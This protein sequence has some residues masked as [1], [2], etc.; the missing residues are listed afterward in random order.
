MGASLGRGLVAVLSASW[1]VGLAFTCVL[2]MWL[3]LVLAGFRGPFSLLVNALSIP[4][5]STWSVDVVPSTLAGAGSG[6]GALAAVI[7]TIVV[8]AVVHAM[9]AGLIVDQLRGGAASHWSI[10]RGLRAFPTTIAV[11]LA[12]FMLLTVGSALAPLLGGLSLFVLLATLVVGVYLF[13]F[14]P[15]V[16]L[17]QDLGTLGALSVSMRAAR[18]PGAGNLA[19]AALYVLPSIVLLLIPKP[20][21]LLGVNPSIDA[22]LLVLAVTLVHLAFQAAFAYRY[23]SVSDEV[24]EAPQRRQ[25]VRK[26]R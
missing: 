5:V 2:A 12:G 18:M 25:P 24:P 6:I 16:A 7:G 23:L 10:V 17:T 14:A 1:V 19:F 21:S 3:G 4:P 11:A 26:T 22:W 8:R 9:F 13:A 20:G 15:V